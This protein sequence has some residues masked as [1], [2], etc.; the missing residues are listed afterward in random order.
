[1]ENPGELAHRE[2]VIGREVAHVPAVV[3]DG[4]SAGLVPYLPGERGDS[5][6]AVFPSITHKRVHNENMFSRVRRGNICRSRA[7]ARLCQKL[8]AQIRV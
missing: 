8:F 5:C 6:G 4:K 3:N 1:M 2:P 7:A